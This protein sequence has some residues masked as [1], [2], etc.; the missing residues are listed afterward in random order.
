MI[1]RRISGKMTP[2]AKKTYT[3]HA[4]GRLDRWDGRLQRSVDQFCDVSCTHSAHT[5]AIGT[6]Q[7]GKMRVENLPF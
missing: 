3:I 4:L 7:A 1:K 5:R 2:G 6:K